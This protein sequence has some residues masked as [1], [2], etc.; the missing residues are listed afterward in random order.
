MNKIFDMLFN[1]W[2]TTAVGLVTGLTAI[3]N[4]LGLLVSPELQ[5]RLSSWLIAA[6]AVLLGLTAKDAEPP[7]VSAG[8]FSRD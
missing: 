1:N 8:G 4:D 7:K 6:V 5:S 2:K 3:L